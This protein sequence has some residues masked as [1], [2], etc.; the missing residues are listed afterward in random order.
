MMHT[1]V[2]SQ[3]LDHK[4]IRLEDLDKKKPRLDPPLKRWG[5]V[6]NDLRR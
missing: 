4:Q 3:N 2:G 5:E 1:G 6:S